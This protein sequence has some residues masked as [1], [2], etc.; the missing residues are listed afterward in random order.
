MKKA[1]GFTKRGALLLI[2]AVV[3]A[4]W[5]YLF[6]VTALLLLCLL[7][8]ILLVLIFASVSWNLSK[9]EVEVEAP[10]KIAAGKQ[11]D[12][13]VRVKNGRVFLDSGAV[14]IRVN[15]TRE[16]S[17][18]GALDWIA[19]RGEAVLD[20][21]I[22]LAQRGCVMEL[23]Y[24]LSSSMP[25]GLFKY[26]CA[27]KSDLMPPLQVLPKKIIPRELLAYGEQQLDACVYGT[28][29]HSEAGD[30]RGLRPWRNGDATKH[31]DWLASARSMERGHGLRVRE[32]EP[33][34]VF[35]EQCHLVF[36]SF[37]SGGA[38][39]REDRFERAIAYLAGSLEYLVNLGVPCTVHADFLGWGEKSCA[40]RVEL[41]ECMAL[42]SQVERS[43]G[44]EAHELEQRLA[45][46][47]GA[48]IVVSEV[49]NALW[50]PCVKVPESAVLIDI[51]QV[52]FGRRKV[53]VRKGELRA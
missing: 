31:I 29:S 42:F 20:L 53:N 37:G 10:A 1:D 18:E 22:V 11:F 8:V 24:E 44:T 16:D 13:R 21:P 52:Q 14:Q 4:L 7:L 27:G 25:F 36:H 50:E 2:G 6:G 12:L 32:Y 46:L 48:I 3:C 35:P 51:L 41:Q 9:L 5:G 39:L 47:K 23:D 17:V 40:S 49:E 34:G 15:L 33:P 38:V 43:V 45:K 26:S 28:A 19:T 30:L